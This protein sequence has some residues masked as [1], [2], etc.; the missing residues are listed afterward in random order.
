MSAVRY[1]GEDKAITYYKKIGGHHWKLHSK[2][3][4]IEIYR[5]YHDNGKPRALYWARV[6]TGAAIIIILT[7]RL[8]DV[9]VLINQIN[10]GLIPRRED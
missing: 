7:I 6:P 10:P 1:F 3:R 9:K 8:G 5:D 2:Y 4:G